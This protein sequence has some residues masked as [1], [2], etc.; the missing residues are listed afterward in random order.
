M[1]L[2]EN[3]YPTP[4]FHVTMEIFK[5]ATLDLYMQKISLKFANINTISHFR[6][7]QAKKVTD[8]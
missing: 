6:Q 4:I 8:I 2:Y 1:M 5:K 7:V 3:V